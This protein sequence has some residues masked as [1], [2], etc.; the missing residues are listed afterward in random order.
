[1]EPAMK[2]AIT[3]SSGTPSPV[4]RMPVWDP[5]GAYL[6]GNIAMVEQDV[7]TMLEKAFNLIGKL[8]TSRDQILVPCKL[9]VLV[10]PLDR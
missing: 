10:P 5:F 4:I 3:A 7:G 1:M 8:Q 2:S 6:P 9:R